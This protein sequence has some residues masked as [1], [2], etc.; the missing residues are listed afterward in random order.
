MG[1]AWID[2]QLDSLRMAYQ[3]A[4][5]LVLAAKGGQAGDA[6]LHCDA[7]LPLLC[8]QPGLHA[9]YGDELYLRLGS[10]LHI[11]WLATAA[12][13]YVEDAGCAGYAARA[14]TQATAGSLYGC[15]S[16]EPKN[17]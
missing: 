17:G 12:R 9:T 14:G 11:L 16:T 6:Y 4:V 10:F 7:W 1:L 13:L 15:P 8:V 5:D 2:H 3:A